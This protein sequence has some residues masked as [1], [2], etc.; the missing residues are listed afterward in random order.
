MFYPLPINLPSGSEP[1]KKWD[2]HP[3]KRTKKDN[4][5]S[6]QQN[7]SK[8]P[9]IESSETIQT[10]S[11]TSASETIQTSETIQISNIVTEKP[12]KSKTRRKS[13]NKKKK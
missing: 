10:S 9:K 2:F 8:N 13:K 4:V 6:I 3:V 11:S 12:K 7:E 1:E 5:V